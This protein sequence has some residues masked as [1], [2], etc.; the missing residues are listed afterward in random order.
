LKQPFDTNDFSR[1]F[2]AEL[3]RTKCPYALA[4]IRALNSRLLHA[5]ICEWDR[6]PSTARDSSPL[7]GQPTAQTGQRSFFMPLSI[8]VGLS[9]MASRDYQSTGVSIIVTVELDQD[10][11]AR[12]EQLQKQIGEAI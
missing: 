7:H 3:L 4:S 1:V 10:L 2:E 8:N 6:S 12:P 11:L 9:R 5:M